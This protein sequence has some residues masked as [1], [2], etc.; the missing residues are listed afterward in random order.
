MSYKATNVNGENITILFIWCI[1]RKY[2]VANGHVACTLSFHVLC[3]RGGKEGVTL[4][5]MLIWALRALITSF[6]CLPTFK[7]VL[8]L[9][10]YFD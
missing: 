1:V 9:V 6:I 10:F 3:P 2:F 5:Q 7:L 4:K 8:K